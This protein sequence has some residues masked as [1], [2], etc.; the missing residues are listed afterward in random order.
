MFSPPSAVLWY[1]VDSYYTIVEN[2]Q[3]LP[4]ILSLINIDHQDVPRI[5]R[6]S[7]HP[8]DHQYDPK[9]TSTSPKSPVRPQDHQYVPRITTLFLG[10]VS[11]MNNQH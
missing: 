4:S 11:Q 1:F 10:E 8:Q 5:T 6:T 2:T 7:V 3:T 9:I